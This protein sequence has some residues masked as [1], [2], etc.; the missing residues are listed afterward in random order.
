MIEEFEVVSGTPFFLYFSEMAHRREFCPAVQRE[1]SIPLQKRVDDYHISL[2]GI[3]ELGTEGLEVVDRSLTDVFNDVLATTGLR[4]VK[5][6]PALSH[7]FFSFHFI[8][9][10][11]VRSSRQAHEQALKDVTRLF[12]DSDAKREIEQIFKRCLAPDLPCLTYSQIH[13]DG[14]IRD[15]FIW[16]DSNLE[17]KQIR[18]CIA[19]EVHNS[20][21]FS[22]S[23]EYS[24]LFDI[25]YMRDQE[26]DELSPLDLLM[27]KVM[28]LDDLVQ[29]SSPT[30]TVKAVNGAIER[31]CNGS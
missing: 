8:D 16:M 10:T 15:A 31:D 6:E 4:L 12:K 7:N 23:A 11:E 24:S 18:R 9:K 25:P 2:S 27:V 26:S 22:E 1:C 20:F 29:N 28:A 5:I 19:E 21:G 14:I 13:E 17:N 30:D 3:G